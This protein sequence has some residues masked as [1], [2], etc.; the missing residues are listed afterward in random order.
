M[1]NASSHRAASRII[2]L[3]SAAEPKSGSNEFSASLFLALINSS[4]EKRE[5]LLFGEPLPSHYGIFFQYVLEAASMAMGVVI[6]ARTAACLPGG[7]TVYLFFP[8]AP[9][10]PLPPVSGSPGRRLFFFGSATCL[11][12]SKALQGGPIPAR[13]P[14]SLGREISL[15]L[16]ESGQEVGGDGRLNDLSHRLLIENQWR[17]ARAMTSEKGKKWAMTYKDPLPRLT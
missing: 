10:G 11:L 15:L 5:D 12:W 8:L 2:S 4:E 3:F 17:Q 7:S 13:R 9:L 14:R 1:P 16:V 6:R